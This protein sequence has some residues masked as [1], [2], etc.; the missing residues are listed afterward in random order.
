MTIIIEGRERHENVVEFSRT[1]T[2]T[3]FN[4]ESKD[5]NFRVES[6]G[7]TDA[8]FID[9][10]NDRVGIMTAAPTVP[11]DVTG[12][13][14]IS[15]AVTADSTITMTDGG[16]ITQQ[17][18]KSTGVTLSTNSGQITTDNAAL[19]AAAEI[20]FT[21][22]NTVVAALDCVIVSLASGA[23]AAEEHIVW[24]GAVGAGSFDICI[25]N[26][27]ASS[28][29]DALVINFVVIKGAAS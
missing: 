15:G 9:A 6:D 17:T 12:A 25:A 22:T 19:A 18:D 24:V 10:G 28:T 11:L 1:T 23:T 20:S 26:V 7:D 21:V 13:T 16:T 8:L 3:V 5:R 29:S 27:S 14:H 4:N 2:E